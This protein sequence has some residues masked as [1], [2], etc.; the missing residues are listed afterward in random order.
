MAAPGKSDL[1]SECLTEG[2]SVKKS[3]RQ[4]EL[5]GTDDREAPFRDLDNVLAQGPQE[6]DE[7]LHWNMS[8]PGLEAMDEIRGNRFTPDLGKKKVTVIKMNESPSQAHEH[9]RQI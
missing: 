8:L 9:S 3:P 6:E 2:S 4:P 7:P 1:C 5:A